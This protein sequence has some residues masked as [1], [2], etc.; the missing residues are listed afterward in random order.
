MF[1]FS[2]ADYKY[3]LIVFVN[4]G[5]LDVTYLCMLFIYFFT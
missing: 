5:E 3:N 1:L 2:R 4:V